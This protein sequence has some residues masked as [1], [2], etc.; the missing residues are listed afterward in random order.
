MSDGRPA[1]HL[2][3]RQFALVV[4]TIALFGIAVWE[5]LTIWLPATGNGGAPPGLDIGI[6]TERTQSWLSG[7]GFYRPRQLAG[8]YRI[9][10]G[11]ALYPPPVVLLFLPWAVGAPIVLWWL[12]PFAV[13]VVSLDRI[14]P[15]LW[16]WTLLAATLVYP[17]TW[18]SIVLGNPS[19]WALAS[20]LAGAAFGWPALGALI[21]PIDAPFALVGARRRSWRVGFV[22]VA[23]VSV[24]FAPMW[25]EYVR[26]LLD[27]R[28]AAGI[29]Y[30]VGEVP[31]AI[32]LTIVGWA[33]GRDRRDSHL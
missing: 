13:V 12:V 17:Y 4:S 30:L 29:T 25:V 26:V 22:L 14:R 32:A 16:A 15:P 9:E 28:N 19:M 3:L 5:V 8:P 31:I 18:V 20:I 27:A 33:G 23:A 10:L 6:Y 11:D 1:G 24:L 21:K 7:E 2:S